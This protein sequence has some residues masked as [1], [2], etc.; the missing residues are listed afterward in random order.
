MLRLPTDPWRIIPYLD[1]GSASKKQD[2][3]GAELPMLSW[4]PG[5]ATYEGAIEPR[6]IHAAHIP[7]LPG[8]S[9]PVPI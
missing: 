1:G 4:P 9:L 5:S 6:A 7:D 3:I 8:A 2:V